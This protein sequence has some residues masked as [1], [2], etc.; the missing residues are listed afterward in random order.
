MA[1]DP[2]LCPPTQN[3]KVTDVMSDPKNDQEIADASFLF[4]DQPEAATP[5]DEVRNTGVR[6]DLSGP[7][8]EDDG[9]DLAERPR[10]SNTPPRHSIPND[11]PESPPRD[12]ASDRKPEPKTITPSPVDP[13]WTRLGE[14][15]PTLVRIA[16]GF[17]ALFGIMYMIASVDRLG[18]TIITL[19]MGLGVIVLLSYPIA[20]TLERPVRMTP[21]HAVRDFYGALSHHVPHMRRMWLILSSSGRSATEFDSYSEFRSYWKER[22]TDLKRGK[23]AGITP[24]LVR[25][26]DFKADKSAGQEAVEASYTISFF[27]RGKESEGP[28]YSVRTETTFSRGPDRMWYLDDGRLPRR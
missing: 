13:P 18:M 20:I 7:D 22:I 25:I 11:L 24:L 3:P 14:W 26:D 8:P 17:A 9:Y 19:L 27:L 16:L 5:A 21:E 15:G 10:A 6:S 12:R 2:R 28:L 1:K 23:A 4:Q